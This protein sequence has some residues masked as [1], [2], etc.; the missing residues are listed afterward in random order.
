LGVPDEGYFRKASCA[1]N[2][3]PTFILLLFA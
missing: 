1:L 3:I 2:V